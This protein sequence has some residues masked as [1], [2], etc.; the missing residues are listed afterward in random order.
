[1]RSRRRSAETDDRSTR[2]RIRDAGLTLFAAQG[3]A[4]TSLRAVAAAAGVAPSHVAHYFGSKAG[5]RTA[6]DEYVAAVLRHQQEDVVASGPDLDPLAALRRWPSELP[7]LDYLARSLVEPSGGSDALVDQLVG[8]AER[9]LAGL[10][11]TGWVRPSAAPR[12]RAALLTFWSLGALTLHTQLERVLGVS[13]TDPDRDPDAMAEYATAMVE[14]LGPGL[15]TAGAV[16]HVRDAFAP[17]GAPAEG[18]VS[19]GSGTAGRDTA[20]P[21]SEE[22]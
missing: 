2:A 9:Y 12:T 20:G 6:C 14:V 21:D 13:L 1:M 16:E 18:R 17:S 8:D 4:A 22:H 10:E 7:L 3:I 5:L 15:F 11:E 19:D